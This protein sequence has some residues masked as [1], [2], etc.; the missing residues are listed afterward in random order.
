M[1]QA[2]ASGAT[3]IL[4]WLGMTLRDRQR[5]YFYNRLDALF[6][7][8]SERYERAYGDRYSCDV[9][10]AAALYRHLHTLCQQ[11]GIVE[12]IP[13]YAPQSAQQLSLF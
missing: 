4:P 6:P 13:P 2:A 10:N 9:P 1:E 3:Y 12:T 8:V 5:A 11:Y 7:G